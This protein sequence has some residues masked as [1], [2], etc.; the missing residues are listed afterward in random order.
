MKSILALICFF[1]AVSVSF[2]DTLYV[3]PASAAGGD[4]QSWNTAY[5]TLNFALGEW[6]TGDEIWLASGTH[7]MPTTGYSLKSGM[8]IYGG[9]AGNETM[10][11]KR[12]WFRQRTVLH[13]EGGGYILRAIDCDSSTRLDGL[14]FEGTVKTAL[15]ITSGAPRIF[16][17]HFR[18]CTA[19]DEASN[20]AA[21]WA[22][23]T[24]RLRIEY[25]V[26]ENNRARTSGAA[27]YIAGS[28]ADAKGFGPF[29][30]QC[31]FVNNS[32]QQGGAIYISEAVGTLQIASCVFY[33][34]VADDAGGAIASIGSYPY[35]TNSTFSKNTLNANP[36]MTGKSIAINGGTIQNSLFWNGDEDTTRHILEIDVPADTAKLVS[37]SNSVEHDFDLGFWQSDP[38]FSNIE[39]PD[40]ADNFYGTDD[41][42]LVLSS[43]SSLRNSGVID[44]FV[45]HRQ[46]DVIGNSRLVGRKI[47]IGAY[48]S[49]RDGRLAPR[50]VMAEMRTGK[51][52]FF[53]RHG[54]TDWDQKDPGPSPE[55]FPGRNLI[56]EGREQFAGVGAQQRML[57]VPIGD[58]NSS[59]VCRCWQTLEIMVGHYVKKDYWASGGTGATVTSRLL[60]LETIPTNGNRAISTHDAVANQVFNPAGDGEIMSTAELMEGDALIV[61]PMGDTMQVIAQWCSDTWERYHVRFPEGIASVNNEQAVIYSNITVAPTP[62]TEHV[63]ISSDSPCTVRVVDILGREMSSLTLAGSGQGIDLNVSTWTQGVYS[64]IG[65]N[66]SGRIIVTR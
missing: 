37:L 62:A 21:I 57:G 56:A 22:T 19:L 31:F 65:A 5:R 26:F 12:D 20:G 6:K 63:I 33:N 2:S 36:A 30:G 38:S 23:G 1:C 44:R 7:T 29:I 25:S 46:N 3:A 49:Q 54:K 32:A 61:R 43:M 8:R 41:D 35:I 40:G 34:N 9:F 24:S 13:S 48:E 60:E 14:T 11:E 16:N 42:G 51:L 66:A 58:A 53:F 18:N 15:A 45:N 39:D 27:L 50:E 47:D 17:C 28:I 59:P 64:I 4:G 52:V 10:R 55:C